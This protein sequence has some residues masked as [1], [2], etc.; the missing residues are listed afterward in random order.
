M[1]R[2]SLAVLTALALVPATASA[3][4]V[5]NIAHRGAS[6]HATEHTFAAYDL[7]LKMGATY[8]EQDLQMTRDG[9]LV[10]LHDDTL[11]RTTDCTGPV[12]TKTLEQLRRCDAG[13]WFDPRF[14]GERIPTLD[15]VFERYGRKVNYYI[16]TKSPESAPG[17]EEALL[18][19]LDEH[20]MR[21]RVILQSFSTAS[22]LRLHTLAPELPLVQLGPVA[23]APQLDAIAAYAMGIGPPVDTVDGA[24]V[25]AAHERDLVV[26][27]Y[28]V[29]ER[30][31][32]AAVVQLGVDG[33]FTNFPDRLREV[34]RER[35]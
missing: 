17:M 26:H 9:V 10:V 12:R 1:S 25:R 3:R 24:L 19:L 6:G 20:G 5:L 18:D 15:E 11:D 16:E 28:T 33:G 31:E 14:A 4:P 23:A 32:L 21:K 29:N 34:L 2:L 13:S 22:L 7:A 35:R 8:I 27:P 30:D